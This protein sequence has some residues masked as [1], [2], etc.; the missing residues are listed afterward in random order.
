MKNLSDEQIMAM[1]NL[2]VNPAEN[3]QV[4]IAQFSA[5]QVQPVEDANE[6][7]CLLGD[8]RLDLEAELGCTELTLKEVIC[9]TQG[10]VITLD[11]IAGD[12]VNVKA[13]KQ[14]LAYGEILA[15]N[16]VLGIRINSFNKEEEYSV[17]GGK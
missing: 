16:E 17:R 6:D 8:V 1:L 7:I 3:N 2:P 11:T 14:W 10:Q 9:L 4:K 5:L 15:L 13:N 12:M